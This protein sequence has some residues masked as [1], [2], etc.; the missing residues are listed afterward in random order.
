MLKFLMEE[1][2]QGMTEYALILAFVA[3]S[4]VV[5]LVA[6]G[7]IIKESYEKVESLIKM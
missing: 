3:L 1:T 4:V 6:F 5:A 2:G 7:E